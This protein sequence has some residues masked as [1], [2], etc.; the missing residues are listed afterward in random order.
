MR[1]EPRVTTKGIQLFVKEAIAYVFFFHGIADWDPPTSIQEL[2]AT[3]PR[4]IY[5]HEYIGQAINHQCAIDDTIRF[6]EEEGFIVDLWLQLPTS[7]ARAQIE[8][9]LEVVRT[10]T[11]PVNLTIIHMLAFAAFLSRLAVQG[12][13]TDL[14]ITIIW[15]VVHVFAR[16]FPLEWIYYDAR[17]WALAY[18]TRHFEIHNKLIEEDPFQESKPEYSQFAG[19]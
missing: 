11:R 5:F 1:S 9:Y 8:L 10:K 18:N 17:H 6:A 13:R 7:E 3:I 14:V 19:P 4:Q 2:R 15:R 12:D 16:H